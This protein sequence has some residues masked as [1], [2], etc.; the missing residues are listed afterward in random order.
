[1]FLPALVVVGAGLV[2]LQV[3]VD[4]VLI[5]EA[6]GNSVRNTSG[7]LV[8]SHESKNMYCGL[9]RPTPYIMDEAFGC[10]LRAD[11]ACG[12]EHRGRRSCNQNSSFTPICIM[13]GSRAL[14]T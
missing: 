12:F 8:N 9:L 7:A 4:I 13:R 6:A 11:L 5:V 1:M 10:C 2:M 14:V 3:V